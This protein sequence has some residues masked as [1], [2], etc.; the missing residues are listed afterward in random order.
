MI[1]DGITVP[2]YCYGKFS[3]VDLIKKMRLKV[4]LSKN[5]SNVDS[6]NVDS[7]ISAFGFCATRNFNRI[8]TLTRNVNIFL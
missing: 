1:H 4:I 3:Y 5:V 2:G 8:S 6:R 7:R